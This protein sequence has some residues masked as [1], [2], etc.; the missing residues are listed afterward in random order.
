MGLVFLDSLR[1]WSAWQSGIKFKAFSNHWTTP[2]SQLCSVSKKPFLAPQR[3]RDPTAS[4][5]IGQ[6]VC[7]FPD[8]QPEAEDKYRAQSPVLLETFFCTSPQ[9]LVLHLLVRISHLEE[10]YS[11]L[12]LIVRYQEIK[13]S[14]IQD[15]N[16]KSII[17]L[18]S[19]SKVSNLL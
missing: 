9:Y 7:P 2:K 19:R 13:A 15:F 4:Y 6:H 18:Q 5:R 16:V 10:F 1:E 11:C 8:G 12:G 14:S 3:D 17:L